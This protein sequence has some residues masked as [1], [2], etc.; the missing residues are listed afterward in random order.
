MIATSIRQLFDC[1]STA[2]GPF[3]DYMTGRGTVNIAIKQHG[4]Y[5]VLAYSVIASGILCSRREDS[6]VAV[7][8]T[9]MRRHLLTYFCSIAFAGLQY[10]LD[11]Y[12]VNLIS[13]KKP[14]FSF[15]V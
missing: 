7:Q 13:P 11:F 14:T 3:N 6:G 15:V 1:N 9:V 5:I 4:G 2:L 8:A 10:F 12:F